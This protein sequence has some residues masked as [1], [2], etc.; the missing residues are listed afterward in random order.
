G[1]ASL[2]TKQAVG[3]SV[4]SFRLPES[5]LSVMVGKNAHPISTCGALV[6]RRPTLRRFC[7]YSGCLKDFLHCRFP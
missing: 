6:G 7:N 2:P 5:V 3:L 1:W 4:N